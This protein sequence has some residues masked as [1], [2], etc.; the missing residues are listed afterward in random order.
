MFGDHL[1]IILIE[2][3]LA[4]N[5]PAP[6][7][8]DPVSSLDD[9][10]SSNALLSKDRR[11]QVSFRDELIGWLEQ[12]P[13]EEALAL[14]D[15]DDGGPLALSPILKVVEA[16][17]VMF[18]TY[19]RHTVTRILTR[20]CDKEFPDSIQFALRMLRHLH[21]FVHDHQRLLQENLRVAYLKGSKNI[22][23]QTNDIKYLV[24]DSEWAVKAL[25]EDV[26][27]FVAISSIKEG[28]LVAMVSK[29]AFLFLPVSTWAAVMSINGPGQDGYTRFIIFGCLTLP[30]LLVSTLM[31][32]FWKPSN[33]DSLEF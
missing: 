3:L 20:H 1:G 31:I 11:K 17:S 6:E 24:Q 15:D 14:F 12:L 25:E 30:S 32:F 13:K 19:A 29:L 5:P 23:E 18:L 33:L 2:K 26:R 27:F 10:F 22:E 4:D 9:S 16:F 7:L 28:K 8:L 21:G